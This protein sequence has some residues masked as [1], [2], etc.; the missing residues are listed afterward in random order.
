M[1]IFVPD[2]FSPNGD[3]INDIFLVH[4]GHNGIEAIRSLKVFSR[5][6]ESVYERFDFPPND[7]QYG[8]DGSHRGQLV[9]PAVFVWFA[10]VELINGDVKL[11]KGEVTVMR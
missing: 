4:A 3:G 5:W 2:A 6:G 9:G 7:P 10:E 11:I 8:W 1:D